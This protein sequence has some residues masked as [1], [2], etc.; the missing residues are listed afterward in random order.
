MLKECYKDGVLDL[1][2]LKKKKKD[3]FPV[4]SGEKVPA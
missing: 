1:D 2:D 4:S 3:L